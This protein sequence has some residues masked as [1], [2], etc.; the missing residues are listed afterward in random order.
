MKLHLCFICICLIFSSCQNKKSSNETSGIQT[1]YI[2]DH[3]SFARR[4][5]DS[6]IKDDFVNTHASYYRH[7]YYQPVYPVELETYENGCLEFQNFVAQHAH[8]SSYRPLIG[9]VTQDQD[10]I[11]AVNQLLIRV[12]ENVKDTKHMKLITDEILTKV[13]AYRNLKIGQKIPVPV[14]TPL[15]KSKIVMYRVDNVFNLSLGMPAFGLVPHTT[16]KTPPILLFR[17]TDLS[18][19]LKGYSSVLAD[20]D[21]NGPGLSVFYRSQ[22]ELHDWLEKVSI[23]HSK[24]RVMGYSLGGSFAQYTCIHEHELICKDKE[25]PSI[26][27]NEPGISE[28]QICKWNQLKKDQRPPLKGYVTEGDLVS[29]VGKLIGDVK[30]LTL[31]HLL[32]PLFAHVTLMSI[33]HRLYAYRLDVTLKNELDYSAQDHDPKETF[34]FSPENR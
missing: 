33:Q 11:L 5:S 25:F 24:A 1:T 6:P 15:G 18:F 8:S 13:L 30:E 20:L 4:S 19:T 31:D 7:R 16:N 22:D 29:T 12:Q 10:D 14:T 2:Y 32:E 3:E 21:L 28:D 23:S 34:Q 17:G 9:I 27:F 26:A